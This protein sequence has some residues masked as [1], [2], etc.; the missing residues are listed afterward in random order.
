M[1]PSIYDSYNTYEKSR[2]K[3]KAYQRKWY[4]DHKAKEEKIKKSFFYKL[5]VFF[6]R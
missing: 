5:A 1:K 6:N 2:N 4:Q 3:R